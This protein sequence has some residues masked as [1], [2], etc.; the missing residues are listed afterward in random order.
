[1]DRV[2]I[3]GI[4]YPFYGT[5]DDGRGII[6]ESLTWWMYPV[7]RYAGE[8]VT[9]FPKIGP[10]EIL[11]ITFEEPDLTSEHLDEVR[12][13]Y[14]KYLEYWRT[15]A[16]QDHLK[17]YGFLPARKPDESEEAYD[18]RR[19]ERIEEL[20]PKFEHARESSLAKSFDDYR[21]EIG[22]SIIWERHGGTEIANCPGMLE[23]VA[24]YLFLENL[25]LDPQ[26]IHRRIFSIQYQ[27]TYNDPEETR[28]YLKDVIPEK[29]SPKILRHVLDYKELLK[30]L[31]LGS[32][33][34]TSDQRHVEKTYLR[35]LVAKKKFSKDALDCFIAYELEGNLVDAA[36]RLGMG[37]DRVRFHLEEC[38]KALDRR[39]VKAARGGPG[40]RK[41][42]YRED[43]LASQGQNVHR[44]KTQS[45]RSVELP[46]D[47]SADFPYDEIDARLAPDT[48]S[49]EE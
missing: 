5:T 33:E 21:Q 32:G 35:R 22:R 28:I 16:V 47:E 4:E 19:A 44:M 15:E 2:I 27:A 11:T 45:G 48:N 26:E 29:H 6:T 23:N 18:S 37:R 40:T 3:E 1:M 17:E 8:P 24:I 34:L 13:E 25:G 38:G 31:D 36:K 49:N 12:E 9:P 7:C 41:E 43:N 42:P 20:T 46:A 14:E 10:K 39:V 30:Q